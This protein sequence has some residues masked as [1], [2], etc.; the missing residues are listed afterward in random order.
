VPRAVLAVL[1]AG[2]FATGPA[3]ANLRAPGRVPHVPSSA[4]YPPP[5]EVEVRGETLAFRCAGRRC[6]VAATYRVH[7]AAEAE[8][9]FEF[10]L[11]VDAGI[12]VRVAGRPVAAESTEAAPLGDLDRRL[13][14]SV[15]EREGG[16]KLYRARFTGRLAAG[17]SEIA[18]AYT[19]PL[20]AH[21]RDYGY[22]KDG[23]WVDVLQYE[24]WPLKEWKRAPDLRIELLVAMRR[25]APGW[26]TRNFGTARSIKCLGGDGPLKDARLEQVGGALEYRATLGPAFPDRLLCHLADEDLL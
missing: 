10:V 1:I 9:A 6:E 5:A 26:W 8:L 7:A 17:E 13:D 4:L 3:A 24:L 2:L 25:E 19:Q 20:G 22:F 23:R 15:A 16:P 12:T 18:V 21:E 14:L 11:P